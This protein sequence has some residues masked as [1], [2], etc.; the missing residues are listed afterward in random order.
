MYKGFVGNSSLGWYVEGEEMRKLKKNI[1]FLTFFFAPFFFYLKLSAVLL[2]GFSYNRP[3]QLW[4]HLESLEEFVSGLTETYIIYK[5]DND[6]YEKAYSQLKKRFPSVVFVRQSMQAKNKDFKEK[7]I[8]VLQKS[9]SKYV[10]FSVDDIFVK[11]S[12]SLIDC[13]D[14]IN[15]TGAYGFYLRLGK[16]I[17][18]SYIHNKNF[19]LPPFK[20]INKNI[21]IWKFKKGSYDWGYPNT[22]DMALYR[23]KDVLPIFY[24]LP[25]NTPNTLESLWVHS[26]FFNKYGLC[27]EQSKIINVPLNSVQTDWTNKNMNYLSAEE[28]LAYFNKGLRIDRSCLSSIKNRSVHMS[29]KPNF[30]KTKE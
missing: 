30:L 18:F 3:L 8:F 4:A 29:W 6:D 23:K 17:D 15:H 28:C 27:F 13:V 24:I 1:F 26:K 11:E 20:Q 2:I 10:I 22:V 7:V 21:L 25:F 12:V 9:L 5:A 19:K 14:A 16:N